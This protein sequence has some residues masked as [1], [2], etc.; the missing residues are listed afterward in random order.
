[1]VSEAI[2]GSDAETTFFLFMVLCF[3]LAW[4]NGSALSDVMFVQTSASIIAIPMTLMNAVFHAVPPLLY[5]LV[6]VLTSMVIFKSISGFFG[7][8]Y[9]ALA[10]V[11]FLVI[12][13]GV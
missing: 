11:A 2:I 4:I 5:P 1:M 6:F 12:L 9:F 3:T 10:I 8:G 7:Q 13:F